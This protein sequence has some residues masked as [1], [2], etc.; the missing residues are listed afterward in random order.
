M[1]S[2]LPNLMLGFHGCSKETYQAVIFNGA[3]LHKST[4]PYDWLGGGIYFW[5][6]NL[7]RA[8]QWAI[9]HHKEDAAVVGAVIDLGRCLNITDTASA[10]ILRNG[11]NA[12]KI[13]CEN[14]GIPLPQNVPS[15][16]RRDVL[17]RNLDCAV[18]EQVHTSMRTLYHYEY[19]D[20]VRGVFWEGNPSYPGSEFYEK[21]HVQ[22]CI[23]NPNCI[24]GYFTPLKKDINFSMP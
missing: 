18:I 13:R 9:E 6:Q 3:Q 19:Y 14:E 12:L 8:W 7:E 20:S 21:T 23:R 2:K 1:Y 4:N 17:A 22:I 5:E 16:K 10:A 24:K 15:K 11:Y